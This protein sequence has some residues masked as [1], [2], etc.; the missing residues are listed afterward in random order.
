[1]FFSR[2]LG[3]RIGSFLCFAWHK[4][5]EIEILALV[6]T[7]E[8]Q[9]DRVVLNIIVYLIEKICGISYESFHEHSKSLEVWIGRGLEEECKVILFAF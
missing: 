2:G 9:K 3:E 4:M 1:M 6:W 5:N 8:K 7:F